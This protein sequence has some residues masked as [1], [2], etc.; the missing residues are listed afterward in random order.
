MLAASTIFKSRY[1]PGLA[2]LAFLCCLL[3]IQLCLPY[4]LL[5][6]STQTFIPIASPSHTVVTKQTVISST[7]VYQSSS[8]LNNF[9]SQPSVSGLGH[10]VT[11][12]NPV[13]LPF[14]SPLPASLLT[15]YPQGG[16]IYLHA[17]PAICINC[18]PIFHVKAVAICLNC[19]P[20]F[21]VKAVAF[22]IDCASPPPVSVGN[23]NPPN[24]SLSLPPITTRPTLTNTELLSGNTV[25][26]TDATRTNQAQMVVQ[27]G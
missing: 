10:Y 13:N 3:I 6:H 14:I 12:N 16:G 24:I 7:P 15:S 4:P 1:L 18:M 20:I 5:A 11:S 27:V 9:I 26:S 8:H 25:L 17:S 21:H 2:K 22:C 19:M 23:S